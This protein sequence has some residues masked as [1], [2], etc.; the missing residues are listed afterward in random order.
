MKNRN[1]QSSGIFRILTANIG[2]IIFSAVFIYI[3][4][5]VVLFLSA[6]HVTAYQVSAGPL[7]KNQTYT[8]LVLRE[9]AVFLADSPGFV[10]YY[11]GDG[12]RVRKKGPVYSVHAGVKDLDEYK[13]QESLRSCSREI[14]SVLGGFDPQNFQDV[15]GLKTRLDYSLVTNASDASGIREGGLVTAAGDPVAVAPFD[16]I[17]TYTIDGYEDFKADG[18]CRETFSERREKTRDV[19]PGDNVESGEE[20]YKLITS[21][22]WSLFIPLTS[23]QIV[24]LDA[25][26]KVRVKFLK[27]GRTLVAAFYIRTAKDGSF[28]GELNFSSGVQQYLGD[29]FLKIELVTNSKTGLKVPLT[30]L[31]SRS[32]LV[33]PESFMTKGGNG[34]VLGLMKVET[35]EEG[36]ERLR[37]VKA[38]V[39]GFFEGNYYIDMDSFV[40][41][42]RIAAPSLDGRKM[43]LGKTDRL[44]GVYSMNKGYTVFRRVEILDKNEDYCLVEKGTRYGIAQFDFIVL[45][46]SSVE[47]SEI[48]AT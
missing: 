17:V 5:S 36:K 29:R 45:D 23:K 20:V 32:F 4:V 40:P 42:D 24:N 21:E 15:Y 31:T 11:V 19:R 33:I 10:T 27:D 3:L 9:E 44:D 47:E 48:T 22:S 43:I 14:R 7:A 13:K 16:G 34:N 41:G 8:G 2:T 18:I 35:D 26:P 30:S 28:Y 12:M 38:T 1:T 25:K 6:S 39:S 37:F 46:A